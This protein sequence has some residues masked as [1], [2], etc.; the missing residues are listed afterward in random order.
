MKVKLVC[1]AK[2]KGHW[3]RNEQIRMLLVKKIIYPFVLKKNNDL[4][5]DWRL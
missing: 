5:F 2:W 1:K 4:R 3:P